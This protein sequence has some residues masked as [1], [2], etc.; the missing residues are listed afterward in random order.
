MDTSTE[1]TGG[2]LFGR[3]VLLL[4]VLFVYSWPTI[5]AFR[6]NH[7]RRF[8]ILVLNL[9]AG[10]IPFVWLAALIWSARRSPEPE[11]V[12]SASTL[13]AFTEKPNR[14]AEPSVPA[15][16]FSNFERSKSNAKPDK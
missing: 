1:L 9:G 8:L 11:S 16:D 13:D 10:W 12:S 3:I 2:T 5:N 15:I 7:H 4:V 14:N 6:R